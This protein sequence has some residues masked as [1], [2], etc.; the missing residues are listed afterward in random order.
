[1]F[2]PLGTQKPQHLRLWEGA[3]TS[4][5]DSKSCIILH[6]LHCADSLGRWGA[7][8]KGSWKFTPRCQRKSWESIESEV[9]S[10][11]LQASSKILM[12]V[13]LKVKP[14]LKWRTPWTKRCQWYGTVWQG[15]LLATDRDRTKKRSH[16]LQW[17]MS[18]WY[19]Q[20]RPWEITPPYHVPHVP[21]IKL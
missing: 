18:R 5:A 16:G 20:L 4:E 11:S 7:R 19:S 21:S 1:M 9:E 3:T 12:N 14:K 15:K 10:E 8:V 2:S 17:A 6:Y 13:V